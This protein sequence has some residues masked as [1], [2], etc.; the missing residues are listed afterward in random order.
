[1]RMKKINWK[2]GV[3][4]A[5]A[6]GLMF[7]SVPGVALAVEVDETTGSGTAITKNW[8]AASNTQLNDAETFKFNLTFNSYEGQ[9]VPEGTQASDSVKA[10][11]QNVELTSTWKTN[12]NGGVTASET[13]DYATLLEGLD[14]DKPGTYFFT[15]SEVDGTNANINYDTET[16]YTVVV[17]V[18][19]A[20]G[21]DNVPTGETEIDSVGVR[22]EGSSEKVAGDGGATFNNTPE[23]NSDVTLTKKVAGTAAD[24]AKDFEFTIQL[25]GVTGEYTISLPDGSS[26]TTQGGRATVKLHHGQSATIENLPKD[27]TYTITE[28]DTTDYT[29]TNT[30]NDESSENGLIATGTV[31][32]TDDTVVFTNEKGFMPQTGITMNTLPFVGVGVVAA[33]GAVTL[34]ISRKR[35]AGED[36]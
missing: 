21:D 10:G 27:A 33:A 5:V 22:A 3:V 26:V 36:F 25:S 30:V 7:A 20:V 9:G 17:N 29:E 2:F 28:T 24:T 31:D 34:V 18:R 32:E 15:L 1:M 35:R 13:M 6:A 8:T 4:S 19:W 23:T 12:A 11:K 16:T 14:F